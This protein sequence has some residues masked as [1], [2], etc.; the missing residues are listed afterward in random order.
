MLAGRHNIGIYEASEQTRTIFG[1]QLYVHPQYNQG[2]FF[3]NDVGLIRAV[4]GFIYNQYVQPIAIPTPGFIHAGFATIHEWGF[5]SQNPIV[6]PDILQT[7]TLPVISLAECQAFWGQ[8]HVG[9]M[10][11]LV[12][13]Q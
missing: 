9:H 1:N 8:V 2:G 5:T 12:V 3:T 6:R 4:P 13:H 10:F 7:V 11:V